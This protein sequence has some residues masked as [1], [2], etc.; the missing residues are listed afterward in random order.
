MYNGP[1][2]SGRTEPGTVSGRSL[3]DTL[4]QVY[5]EM[6]ERSRAEEI[7]AEMRGR[8]ARANDPNLIVSSLRTE[9]T[10]ATLD[11]H[12]EE[13]FVVGEQVKIR[14]EELGIPSTANALEILSTSYARL[15]LGRLE[16]SV[17]G[18][19]SLLQR[20]PTKSASRLQTWLEGVSLA[21]AGRTAEAFKISREFSAKGNHGDP[22]DETGLAALEFMLDLAVLVDDRQTVEVLYPRLAVLDNVTWVGLFGQP[23]HRILGD[24]AALL[25][26]HGAARAHY[27]KSLELTGKMRFRPEIAL[28]RL[29]VAELLLEHYPDE[30]PEALEHMD[31]AIGELRDMKMSPP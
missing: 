18:A 14:G 15:H 23:V 5:L 9:V 4:G 20:S 28:T 17:D 26:D 19:R 22:E 21:I 27:L 10:I 29:Q 13:A 12:L 11:G 30:R 2:E 8:A 31:F 24:A 25:G 6:G 1:R 16:E 3:L 7:W